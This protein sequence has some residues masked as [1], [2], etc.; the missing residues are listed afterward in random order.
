MR[1]CLVILAMC[2]FI[3]QLTLGQKEKSHEMELSDSIFKPDSVLEWIKK[4]FVKDEST[5][6]MRV[7]TNHP[8]HFGGANLK[9]PIKPGEYTVF[10][11]SVESIYANYPGMDKYA[12]MLRLYLPDN[13]HITQLAAQIGTP[14]NVSADEVASG[15]WDIMFWFVGDNYVT[16][17]RNYEAQLDDNIAECQRY[18]F[19]NLIITN[20]KYGEI[21]GFDLTH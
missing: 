20:S 13:A 11:E 10:G 12:L 4:S 6:E 2:L 18:A 15:M 16:F 9:L 21:P 14:L 7:L 8:F 17:S 19:Y 1:I 5:A 3:P